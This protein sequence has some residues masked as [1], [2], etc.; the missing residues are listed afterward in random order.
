MRPLDNYIGIPYASKGRTFQAC[1]CWGIVSLFYQFVLHK[2]L[3]PLNGE[4]SDAT[5]NG[6][7]DK[8]VKNSKDMFI[9]VN[10]NER[11]YG[12]IILFNLQGNPVHAGVVLDHERMLHSLAGHNSA[13]ERYTSPVWDR[14]IEG[15]YRTQGAS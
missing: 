2:E 10:Y 3:P 1:D 4:Y 5:N 11:Q 6:E 13:V 9:E 15:V 7:V 12:D 8:V 14:R